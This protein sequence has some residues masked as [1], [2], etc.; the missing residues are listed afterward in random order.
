MSV[1]A[2]VGETQRL[3]LESEFRD[4]LSNLV[5]HYHNIN[6]GKSWEGKG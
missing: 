6:G 5:R 4:R 1:E 3:D 2:D